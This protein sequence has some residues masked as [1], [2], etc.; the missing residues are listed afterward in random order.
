M[1]LGIG[2]AIGVGG[3]KVVCISGDGGFFLNL[4]KLWTAAKERADAVLIVMNDRGYGVIRHIQDSLYEGRRYF[5]DIQGPNFEELAKV[6][7]VAYGKVSKASELGDKVAA[8]IAIDGPA[9]V[10]VDMEAIGPY[11]PYFQP[12][13][14]TRK[15]K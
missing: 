8:A 3:R 11:P 4:T 1:S 7:G 13:P 10:E 9:L 6:A 2:A 14:F 12:P 15:E 5:H